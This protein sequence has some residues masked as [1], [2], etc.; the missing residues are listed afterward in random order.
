MTFYLSR[1]P[2]IQEK[3]AREIQS[4]FRTYDEIVADPKLYSCKYLKAIIQETLRTT[5]PVPAELARAVLRGGT[6]VEGNFF[7]KDVQVSTSLYCLSHNKETYEKPFT[8]RPE[9]WIV[10]TEDPEGDSAEK[11]ELAESG[12]CAFSTGTRGCVGKNLAW[13]EMML[14]MAKMVFMYELKQDPANNLGGGKTKGSAG[15]QDPERYQIQDAF[16]AL[17]DGPLVQFKVRA[18]A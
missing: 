15:H 7:P 14:V 10:D 16:I 8:F 6:S 11:V 3:L 2:R 13:M 18:R 4:T 5:P 12:F 9:R 17:R 1:N